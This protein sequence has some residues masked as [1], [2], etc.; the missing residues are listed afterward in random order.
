MEDEDAD[1]S[2]AILRSLQD[3][4]SNNDRYLNNDADILNYE[5]INQVR[6]GRGGDDDDDDLDAAIQ[7]SL[8]DMSGEATERI[9]LPQRTIPQRMNNE[10]ED[11]IFRRTQQQMAG[12][13]DG[14]IEQHMRHVERI[15]EQQAQHNAQQPDADYLANPFNTPSKLW[16]HR[17]WGKNKI[18]PKEKLPWD[19]CEVRRAVRSR[20]LP[21]LDVI[22][23][24]LNKKSNEKYPIFEA[25]QLG[26]EECASSIIS[27][28]PKMIFSRN[29][30]GEPP[31]C[32]AAR[33]QSHYFYSTGSLQ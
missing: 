29:K 21:I 16:S 6:A 11:I 1:I 23:T 10:N 31:L 12:I 2:V 30:T 19:C 4:Y 7:A 26:H 28:F 27:Y 22:T 25:I 8:R 17:G 20:D 18:P 9:N 3:N 32:H 33:K 5:G 24:E 13:T 14:D 15:E